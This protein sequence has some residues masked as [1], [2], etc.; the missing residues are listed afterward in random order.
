MSPRPPLSELFPSGPYRF[1]LTLKRGDAREFFGPQDPAGRLLAE[2]AKW[3]AVDAARYAA[4]QPEGESLLA[5]VADLAAREW[6]IPG[7]ASVLELGRR[8]EPD[9]LLLSPDETGAFRLR[10]GALCFP[11]GWALEEKLGHKLD[12]IH[13]V[14]PGLNAALAAPIHQFLSRLKPG[15]VFFRDNWGIVTTDELNL[16]PSRRVSAP[17]L[18]VVLERLWLRL[19][20]QALLALPRTRGVLF[21]IRIGLHRLDE[22]A[23][24]RAAA[25][26]LR[27]ALATMPAEMAAYKRL[28]GIRSKLSECV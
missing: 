25:A 5:E 13:G 22:V 20:Y 11:T 10:G 21:G 28:D 16:H 23:R 9:M 26:G 17:V 15:S 19:E 1:H 12:F 18:P 8:L 4:L 3:I 7:V 2:R 24:D 27:N 6:G 14:V